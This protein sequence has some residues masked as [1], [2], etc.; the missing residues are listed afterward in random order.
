MSVL[1]E[2]FAIQNPTI[3]V[4]LIAIL[5]L[6][7]TVLVLFLRLRF[8]N[9]QDKIFDVMGDLIVQLGKYIQQE[10]AHE[11]DHEAQ[12]K[13]QQQLLAAQTTAIRSL[14][15]S[16]KRFTNKLEVDI[17]HV[18]VTMDALKLELDVL[19]S[20]IKSVK[21]IESLVK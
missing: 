7:I 9:R 16:S 10:N 13:A 17:E 4:L 11:L 5:L 20:M 21:N 14:E 19:T 8:G 3:L 1:S 12:V 2:L 15:D 6:S 18:R